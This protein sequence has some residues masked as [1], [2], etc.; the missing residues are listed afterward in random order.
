MSSGELRYAPTH[1]LCDAKYWH[2]ALGYQPTHSLSC[3]R[4]AMTHRLCRCYAVS[5]T[6]IAYGA[7]VLGV[8]GIATQVAAY[9]LP[10]RCPVLT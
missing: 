2:V 1:T 9:A 4:T 5:G 10:M 6:E 8:T 3:A 7:T